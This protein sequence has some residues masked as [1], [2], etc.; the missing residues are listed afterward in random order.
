MENKPLFLSTVE[1]NCDQIINSKYFKC[2][3]NDNI[4]IVLL[5][6][7]NM[8]KV[9]NDQNLLIA[10]NM[11][12]IDS[13]YLKDL[14]E[15]LHENI[16]VKDNEQK[17]KEFVYQF[18]VSPDYLKKNSL[19]IPYDVLVNDLSKHTV[20][21][22]WVQSIASLAT[23][24]YIF[25]LIFKQLNKYATE[26]K[27][28]LNESPDV[29]IKLLELLNSQ[30]MYTPEIEKGISETAKSFLGMFE[31]LCEIFFNDYVH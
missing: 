30:Q 14:C 25:M 28:R 10:V 16:C 23:T 22:N 6:I 15:I 5:S 17:F 19:L 21:N 1:N 12:K 24:E 9:L 26:N 18:D 7:F 29:A 4:N 31:I 20:D 13:L 2:M 27:I 11:T 3:A 8:K